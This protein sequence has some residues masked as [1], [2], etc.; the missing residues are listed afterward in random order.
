MAMIYMASQFGVTVIR[1]LPYTV[2][3]LAALGID[4][5]EPTPAAKIKCNKDKL[6][7]DRGLAPSS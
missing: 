7:R 2:D 5:E 1:L 6:E 3:Q 4:V